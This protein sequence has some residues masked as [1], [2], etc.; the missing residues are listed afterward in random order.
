MAIITLTTQFLKSCD[1]NKTTSYVI[2][3]DGNN[4]CGHSMMQRL[5]TEILN[6]VNP[7]DFNIDNCSN[8]SQLGSF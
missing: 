3:L 4:L 2:Y 1:A 6:W 8:D 7:K 5:P